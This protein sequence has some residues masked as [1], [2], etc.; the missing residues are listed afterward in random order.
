VR[1]ISPSSSLLKKQH[2]R[3]RNYYSV[4]RKDGTF[5][6]TIENFLDQKVE[7][8]AMAVIRMLANS[9]EQPK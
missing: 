5:D 7:S 8:P 4:K 2:D 1:K 6:D 3:Q 9:N